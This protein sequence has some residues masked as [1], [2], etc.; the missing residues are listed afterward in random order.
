[1]RNI[2]AVAAKFYDPI[3]FI[4]P[5]VVQ[6]KLLFQDLCWSGADW[7]DTLEGQ[8]RKKWVK[9]VASLQ[10]SPALHL[11]RCYFKEPPSEI[12]CCNLHSFC[13]ASLKAY[14]TVVYLQ[15]HTVSRT[16]VKF[17]ASKTRVAPL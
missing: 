5:V 12:V 13:D 10:N 9:L 8:L 4:S 1:M 16:Y 11:E 2:A 14:G 17:V 7:D 15:V 3:G 6:F